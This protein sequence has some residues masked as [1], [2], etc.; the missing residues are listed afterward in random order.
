VVAP[1]FPEVIEIDGIKQ[2]ESD[3]HD[4]VVGAAISIDIFELDPHG[5]LVEGESESKAIKDRS[6]ESDFV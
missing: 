3:D 2:K 6:F 4:S 5:E 1:F